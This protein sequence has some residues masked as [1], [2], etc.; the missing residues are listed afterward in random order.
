MRRKPDLGLLFP[1]YIREARD[2]IE[3]DTSRLARNIEILR[4]PWLD[5]RVPDALVGTYGGNA[6]LLLRSTLANECVHTLNRLFEAPNRRREPER[7]ELSI[8]FV[9]D[10]LRSDRRIKRIFRCNQFRQ[11]TGGSYSIV[12]DGATREQTFAESFERR[13]RSGVEASKQALADLELTA[14]RIQEFVESPAYHAVRVYRVERLAHS[15]MNAHARRT[16]G[17]NP[18]LGQRPIA[19]AIEIFDQ[20][21]NLASEFML[22]V[23]RHHLSI[24]DERLIWRGYSE[25]FWGK[26]SGSNASAEAIWHARDGE[27]LR[28][29]LRHD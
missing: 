20:A 13:R 29:V 17:D 27:M 24:D 5:R 19:D 10:Q 16:L 14:Q 3:R 1:E 7:Q 25:E 4:P 23:F 21:V 6:L 9:I 18:D 22:T 12:E 28:R 15:V 26:I 11:A 8:Q 2:R